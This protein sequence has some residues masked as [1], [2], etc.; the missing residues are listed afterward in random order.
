M[1]CLY[2]SL[3][4]GLVL[5]SLAVPSVY[6]ATPEYTIEEAPGEYQ[7]M[8]NPQTSAADLKRGEYLYQNKCSECHGEEGEGDG[9]G[10]V[11]FNDKA[12]MTERT[13]GQLFYIAM[14]GNGE[15]AE[16]EGYGPESD[17]GM[18]EK[19]LWQMVTYIRTLV[20]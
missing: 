14:E 8:E 15:D 5:F 4:S 12:Y 2:K 6:A 11:I 18:S 17:Y 19:K 3:L 10:A 20:K 1:R 7:S 16:M 13:D 9:D